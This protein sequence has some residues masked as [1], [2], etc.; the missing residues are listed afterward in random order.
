MAHRLWAYFA[1]SSESIK[2]TEKK[3]Y[4][5]KENWELTEKIGADREKWD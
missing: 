1:L 3:A 2:L 4:S 5:D